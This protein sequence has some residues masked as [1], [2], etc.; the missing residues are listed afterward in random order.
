MKGISL[1]LYRIFYEIGRT[2]NLTRAA[3]NL[4]VSQP[5]I[6]TA[7]KALE[8]QLNTPLCIRTK[9]GVQ[10]TGEGTVLYQ[11]LAQAFAHVETAER[12]IDKLI[13]LDSGSISISA[14]DTICNYFLLPY[15]VAF[16]TRHPHIRLGITN[17]TSFETADMLQTGQV[18][19]GFIHLPYHHDDLKATP[20]C[21][22][23]DILIGGQQYEHL[24]GNAL[25]LAEV[26]A[27]PLILLEQKS[28]SRLWLDNHF[29]AQGITLAPVLELGSIDLIISFVKNNMGLAFIPQELCG[30]FVDSKS[31]FCLPLQEDLPPRGLG[32][33]ESKRAPSSHAAEQFKALVLDGR[34]DG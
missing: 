10:L 25:S 9:K 12:Q 3:E 17:R 16:T 20:C 1:D 34:A 13:H 21:D 7:L 27:Y 19:F 8:N 23:N 30:H 28:N 18:D 32:L 15:I 31:I 4:Y 26:A 33:L 2:G 11:E 6:S 24:C 5:N 14:S 29:A 22:V